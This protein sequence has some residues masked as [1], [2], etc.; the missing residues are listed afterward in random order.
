MSIEVKEVT[1]EK[2]ETDIIPLIKLGYIID[3]RNGG[4]VKIN[5]GKAEVLDEEEFNKMLSEKLGIKN[6]KA[7]SNKYMFFNYVGQMQYLVYQAKENSSIGHLEPGTIIDEN[8]TIKID[9][10][11][12][13]PIYDEFVEKLNPETVRFILYIAQSKLI[14]KDENGEYI[15]YEIPSIN[16]EPDDSIDIS[17]L[18]LLIPDDEFHILINYDNVLKDYIQSKHRVMQFMNSILEKYYSE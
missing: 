5:D 2:F 16:E 1:I 14:V 12:F 11:K 4:L 10:T 7:I 15:P 9:N 17:S 8:Q 3:I 13:K 18:K 6:E